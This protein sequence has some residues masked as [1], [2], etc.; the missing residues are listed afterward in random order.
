M[1]F[2]EFVPFTAA[3]LAA[4]PN[5]VAMLTNNAARTNVTPVLRI[6]REI[7]QRGKEVKDQVDLLQSLIQTPVNQ[8][9]AI[10]YSDGSQWKRLAP[11]AGGLKV[12]AIN[13]T[14]SNV[15]FWVTP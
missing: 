14:N 4:A 2:E 12:L 1:G 5:L 6:L 3:E 10:L 13:T 8:A 15:P 7:V 9:G 11:P